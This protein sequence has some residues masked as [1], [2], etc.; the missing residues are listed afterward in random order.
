[1]TIYSYQKINEEIA[2]CQVLCIFCHKE[3]THLAKKPETI[4]TTPKKLNEFL[5][6]KWKQRFSIL[7]RSKPCYLCHQNYP[8]YQMELDH[9]PEF[10]KIENVSKL[11]FL[12]AEDSVILKEISK[13]KAI[14][15]AC[16]RLKSLKEKL[17]S[18]NIK[19]KLK[20]KKVNKLIPKQEHKICPQCK[21]EKNKIYFSQNGWCK[22]CFSRYRKEKRKR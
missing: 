9:Q 1:M 5:A 7:A 20:Y 3:K 14:C 21:E 6:T 2:K 17:I 11:I 13:T 18:D 4:P 12:G 16:H 10:Q 19:N 22:E 15:C 8:Y